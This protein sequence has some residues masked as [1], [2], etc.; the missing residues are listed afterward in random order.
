MRTF[1]L[2]IPKGQSKTWSIGRHIRHNMEIG[3]GKWSRESKTYLPQQYDP[4]KCV[5]SYSSHHQTLATS[6]QSTAKK[7]IKYIRQ[8]Q[9]KY[10]QTVKEQFLNTLMG[11]G[12]VNQNRAG[13][14]IVFLYGRCKKDFRDW[15]FIHY[16]P[17]NTETC[18]SQKH[19]HLI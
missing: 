2:L 3:Y 17:Q 7:K 19:L 15:N 9:N 18:T 4:S 16:S 12:I 14:T 6:E 1:V 5:Y 10:K 8:K 13:C 11:H